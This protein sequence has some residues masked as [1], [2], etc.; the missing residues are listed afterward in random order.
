[1]S[2][3][4]QSVLV[5]VEVVRPRVALQPRAIV[6]AMAAHENILAVF[7]WKCAAATEITA[8]PASHRRNW[9]SPF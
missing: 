1:M 5:T 9:P 2:F 6:R 7:P 3:F 8:I 4:R